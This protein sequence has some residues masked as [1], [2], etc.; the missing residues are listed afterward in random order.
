VPRRHRA[1]VLLACLAV[2]GCAGGSAEEPAQR[3]PGASDRELSATDLATV[4]NAYKAI[5]D[6][7]DGIAGVRAADGAARA[8]VRVYRAN[9]PD[10]LADFNDA[11][12]A[13]NLRATRQ[14][15]AGEMRRCKAPD[16][17]ARVLATTG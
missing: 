7:C 16:A 4:A 10:A 17:A 1:S 3:Q 8:L 9:S 12:D 13:L 5:R 15:A 2:A 14:R 6:R 11:D